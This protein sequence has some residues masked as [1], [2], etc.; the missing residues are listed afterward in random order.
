[1][2][3]FF[4]FFFSALGGVTIELVESAAGDHKGPSSELLHAALVDALLHRERQ[5]AWLVV[6]AWRS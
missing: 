2:S 4:L 6:D 1:M 3:S 5:E